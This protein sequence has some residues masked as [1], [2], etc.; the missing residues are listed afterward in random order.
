M[1]RP[2][3]ALLRLL[4]SLYEPKGVTALIVLGYV[5]AVGAGIWA[6]LHDVSFLIAGV[7]S[8]WVHT[9]TVLTLVGGGTLGAPTAWIGAWW[10]ERAA[11]LSCMVGTVYVAAVSPDV[12]FL[13][14]FATLLWLP[15][16]LRVRQAPFAPGRGPLTPATKQTISDVLDG[17][18][19]P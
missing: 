4:D 10:L 1:G 2:R 9:F 16:F 7:A 13:A 19:R 18:P 12:G 11:A 6:A 14:P 3:S 5:Y 15:R 8:P 17:H